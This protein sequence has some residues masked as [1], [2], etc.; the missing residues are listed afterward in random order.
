MTMK[1][2]DMNGPAPERLAYTMRETAGMLGVD[3]QTVY[4]LCKRGLLRSSSALRTKLF[5]RTEIERFL[6][7]TMQ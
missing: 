7:E 3:Y 5:A 1:T 4:R 6:K 2:T